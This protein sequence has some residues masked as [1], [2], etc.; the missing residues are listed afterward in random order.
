M[1]IY[2]AYSDAGFQTSAEEACASRY[3][4]NGCGPDLL[5]GVLSAAGSVH[6]QLDTG[7]AADVDPPTQEGSR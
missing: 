7:A 6:R 1:I 3:L 2:S 4:V 5:A